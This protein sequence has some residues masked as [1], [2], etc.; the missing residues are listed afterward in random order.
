MPDNSE[1]LGAKLQIMLNLVLTD[2]VV[3]FE[4]Q[5]LTWLHR[6]ALLIKQNNPIIVMERTMQIGTNAPRQI[7]NFA[8]SEKSF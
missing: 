3:N 4:V 5:E 8:S 6:N 1:A 7:F 2:T